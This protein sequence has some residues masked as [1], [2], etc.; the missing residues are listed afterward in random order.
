MPADTAAS[1]TKLVNR[2]SAD[3]NGRR[4]VAG[5]GAIGA[6]KLQGKVAASQLAGNE[7]VGGA[8]DEGVAGIEGG[9][10][11]SIFSSLLF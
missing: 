10:D 8:A 7:H 3:T 4:R 9:G 11:D 2:P 6:S 5:R 1:Y